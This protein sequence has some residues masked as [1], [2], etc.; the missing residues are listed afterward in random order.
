[1]VAVGTL[2]LLVFQG[3]LVAVQELM[4]VFPAVLVTHR[5][6]LQAK[7]IMVEIA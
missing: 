7:A 4:G 6:L 5:L 1:V 3:V 2:A